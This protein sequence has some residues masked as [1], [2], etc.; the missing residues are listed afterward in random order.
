[1]ASDFDARLDELAARVGNGDLTG[2]LEVNQVYAHYQHEGLDLRHPNGGQAKFLETALH[3]HTRDYLQHIADHVLDSGPKDAMVDNVEQLD[4]DSAR[5]TP[6]EA[7]VLARSGHPTVID[8]G[9]IVYDRAPEVP[10]LTEA[11]LEEIHDRD[12]SIHHP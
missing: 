1:M 5:L 11:E 8:D 2:Q 6:K 10:R 9:S 3:T 4:N 12:I 7:T